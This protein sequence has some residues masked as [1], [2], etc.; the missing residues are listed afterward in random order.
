M[1]NATVFYVYECCYYFPLHIT[2]THTVETPDY[3]EVL[4]SIFRIHFECNNMAFKCNCSKV[5]GYN[6]QCV[7][8][9]HYIE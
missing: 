2:H 6:Q 1:C 8:N 4:I 7:F 9:F 5:D 3:I